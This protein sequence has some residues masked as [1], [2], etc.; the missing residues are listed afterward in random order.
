MKIFK[1]LIGI[2]S[3]CC[4]II[5]GYTIYSTFHVVEYKDCVKDTLV[6]TPIHVKDTIVI[7][8]ETV[9]LVKTIRHFS[10]KPS[11][12]NKYSVTND[13]CAGTTLPP[14]KTSR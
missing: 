8:V 12:Y 4:L 1:I 14:I 6:V 13:S 2:F 7:R 9:R 10:R 5:M 3:L 11:L